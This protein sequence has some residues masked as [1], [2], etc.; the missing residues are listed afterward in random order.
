M[1]DPSIKAARRDQTKSSN[2]KNSFL[3]TLFAFALASTLH[4]AE[5]KAARPQAATYLS[6]EAARQA[7]PDF[8][9]Q[10]EYADSKLGA[11]V[12]ALG[13]DN[14]RVVFHKGGLPGAGWDKSAKVELEAK[15]ADDK[16]EF[17]NDA[18]KATLTSSGLNGESDG[19]KFSLK[20]VHR[21]SPRLGAKPPA[22]AIVLFDGSNCDA[23]EAGH[24]DEQGRMLLAPGTKTKRA[25]FG[26][27]TLHAEFLLPFKPLGRGQDRGN[28][29]IYIQDRYEIQVLDSFGLK[30]E[31]NEC[32]AL[33][34]R[35]KPSVNMC[36][37]PLVWQSYDIDFEAAQFDAEG[38]KVKNAVVTVNHNGVII[39]DKLD[40]PG[41][42]GGGKAETSPIGPIQLQGHGNPV[43]YRNLWVV[44][45]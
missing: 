2:M 16:V 14:F 27:F 31:N 30:G 22:G 35:V 37:P 1:S 23:W 12:I 38:K 26:S 25:D 8:D 3:L 45:K 18:W 43:F 7:G 5:K 11:Q 19:G 4:A 21:Q 40:V 33:Y 6:E 42:T 20:K 24:F 17:A 34:T 15:R 44:T 29:G 36:F 39:H 9:L 10:G 32:G 13:N 28:S 41:K